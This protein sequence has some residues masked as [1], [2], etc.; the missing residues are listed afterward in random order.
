MKSTKFQRPSTREI[1]T[2]NIQSYKLPMQR[3]VMRRHWS[4]RLGASLEVGAWSLALFLATSALAQSYSIDWYKIAGGGGVTTSHGTNYL[5]LT[6]PMGN[7]FFRLK[8]P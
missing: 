1:S 3:H 7:L 5:N 8:N 2:S 4:L 6:A